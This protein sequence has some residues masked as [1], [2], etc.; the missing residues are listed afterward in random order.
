MLEKQLFLQNSHHFWQKIFPFVFLF[1]GGSYFQR[2]K[3]NRDPS[4]SKDGYVLEQVMKA[5]FSM[6]HLISAEIQEG[7]RHRTG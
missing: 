5:S 6:L 7:S 2:I 1:F 4:L 3:E